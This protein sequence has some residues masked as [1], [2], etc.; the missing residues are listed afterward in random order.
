MN[1]DKAARSRQF[2]T[3]QL[4]V[5]KDCRAHCRLIWASG[6]FPKAIV[7][8]LWLDR[9]FNRI[10]QRHVYQIVKSE[11]LTNGQ[12]LDV[13]DLGRSWQRTDATLTDGAVDEVLCRRSL[14]ATDDDIDLRR[15]EAATVPSTP[16]EDLVR[17]LPSKSVLSENQ[18][19]DTFRN[20]RG[21]CKKVR[22]IN[23]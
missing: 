3:Y 1:F 21:A 17:P 9:V 19:G 15:S 8:L 13:F 5:E 10:R 18:T 11:F 7:T 22:R 6:E 16:A 2:V 23:R 14:E 20:K 12:H 4:V